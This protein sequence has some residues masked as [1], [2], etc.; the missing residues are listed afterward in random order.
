MTQSLAMLSQRIYRI[1]IA[2]KIFLFYDEKIWVD[3][4]LNKSRD[5]VISACIWSK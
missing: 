1:K 4:G 5:Y 3:L 2:S